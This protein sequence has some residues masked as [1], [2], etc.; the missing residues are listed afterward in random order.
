ME[1]T[2]QY[3]TARPGTGELAVVGP[4]FRP[5]RIGIAV[6]NG[7]PLRKTINETLL[8]MYEDGTYERTY[9]KWFSP[10]K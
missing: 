6:A 10:G 5:E 7:S 9:G 3:C 4:I 1:P 2:L 8:A